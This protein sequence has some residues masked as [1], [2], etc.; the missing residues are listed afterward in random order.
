MKIAVNDTNSD[1]APSNGAAEVFLPKLLKGLTGKG[2]EVHLIRKSAPTEEV[3]ARIEQ[4]A[5]LLHISRLKLDGAVENTAP[6]AA[7]WLAELNPDVYL[8][9]NA[10]DLGWAVLP[11]LNPS[12][13]TLAVGHA[14][15]ETYYAPARHYRSFLTRVVGTT[16][17]VCV[18]FVLSC[19]IDK[20]RV[21]WISYGELE[22]SAAESADEDLEKVIETYRAC[23][24]KAIADAAAAPREARADF[25]P[26]STEPPEST[27]WFGKLKA[28]IIK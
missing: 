24:E 14:D 3:L 21:E 9:W 10:D 12:I 4:A 13:A 23:F 15:A 17:E 2:I 26:L 8:I 7:N 16:P 1:N 28:K 20:E 18:G 27:S 25:P 19:V 6:D 11:R 22:G 5:P